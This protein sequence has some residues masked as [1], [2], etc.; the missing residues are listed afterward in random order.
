MNRRGL[1]R[2]G[3]AA[4]VAGVAGLAVAD[5]ITATNAE[6][7]AGGAMVLG[8]A[9][10]SG[11]TPTSLTSAAANG[12][13]LAISNTGGVAPLRLMEA[14]TPASPAGLT[15]GDLANFDGDL[16]YT[17][18]SAAGPL[19]GFVYSEF[20]ANQVVTFKPQRVLDTRSAIGRANV[21]NPTGNF[22]AAGRLRA[23]HTIVVSVDSLVV[24]AEAAFCN[25][26]A[27][28]PLTAGFMTLWPDGARSVAS[29]INFVAQAVI[30]NS[31][32]TGTSI[33]DTVSIF[34]TATTHV[35]LDVTAV[36]VGSPWQVNPVILASAAPS[37][38]GSRLAARAKAGTL[39]GWYAAR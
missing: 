20:T 34:S 2:A 18:G 8:A 35:V 4:I 16:F 39:P 36:A 37:A 31:A 17:A 24:G 14:L 29:S 26:V 9:N 30:A 5:T 1:L 23:G 10:E 3:G 19:T 28:I 22:D 11:T 7:A 15:S 25:L 6:A 32:V 38:T 33:D 12:P 21:T 13:T 27:V